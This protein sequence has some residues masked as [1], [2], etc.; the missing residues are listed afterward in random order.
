MSILMSNLPCLDFVLED[1]HELKF[2]S[3]LSRY[4]LAPNTGDW[5]YDLGD[6][7][8]KEWVRRIEGLKDWRIGELLCGLGSGNGWM[9]KPKVHTCMYFKYG[10]L[11]DVDKLKIKDGL[12]MWLCSIPFSSPKASYL[13]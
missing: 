13:V 6:D 3:R 2:C 12:F 4:V 11:V 10:D 8:E 7:A 1:T 9:A 5:G